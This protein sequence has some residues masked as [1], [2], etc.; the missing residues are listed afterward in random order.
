M[1]VDEARQHV[2]AGQIEDG[3]AARGMIA[4]GW[5]NGSN[6][7]AFDFDRAPCLRDAMDNVDYSDVIEDE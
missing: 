3:S 4:G 2:P 7:S 1:R 5:D 6:M